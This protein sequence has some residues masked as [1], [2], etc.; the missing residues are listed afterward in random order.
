MKRLILIG[1][2]LVG[3]FWVSNARAT[4][5]RMLVRIMDVFRFGEV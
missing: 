2:A 5:E 1:I 3:L 4:I